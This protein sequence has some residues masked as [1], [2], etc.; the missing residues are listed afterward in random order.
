LH[1]D[2][3][4]GGRKSDFFGSGFEKLNLLEKRGRGRLERE[5]KQATT[6]IREARGIP[7][8]EDG[9]KGKW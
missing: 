1:C 6:R 7:K 9:E 5:A 8:G 3:L 2:W 4:W